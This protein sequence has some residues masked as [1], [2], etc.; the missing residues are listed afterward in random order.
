M[1]CRWRT[2]IKVNTEV[3]TSQCMFQQQVLFWKNAELL[4]VKG[5]PPFST[6]QSV[7]MNFQKPTSLLKSIPWVNI[8]PIRLLYHFIQI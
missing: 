3:S 1:S 6:K 7:C 5:L 4:I 8:T 2:V